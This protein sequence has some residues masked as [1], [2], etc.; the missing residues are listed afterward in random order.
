[1]FV[2]HALAVLDLVLRSPDRSIWS[3]HDLEADVVHIDF[4]K[5]ADA[6][7]R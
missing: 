3:S 6:P 2:V 5:P 1:M 7:L 4:R